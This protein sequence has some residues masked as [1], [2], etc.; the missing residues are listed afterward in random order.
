M[1]LV[2]TNK[3]CYGSSYYKYLQNNKIKSLKIDLRDLVKIKV[4]DVFNITP[5]ERKWVI[6]NKQ[7]IDLTEIKG[8]YHCFEHLDISL[9]DDFDQRDV[10]Y[11]REEWFAYIVFFLNQIKKNINPISHKRYGGSYFS[12]LSVYKFA[13]NLGFNIPMF[14]FGSYIDLTVKNLSEYVAYSDIFNFLNPIKISENEK[15]TSVV[16]LIEKPKG[17]PILVR[18]IGD[19][20]TATIVIKNQGLNEFILSDEYI[21]K[22]IM[23][24]KILEINVFEVLCLNFNNKLIFYGLSIFP[25]W[26]I[27]HLPMNYYWEQITK[28]IGE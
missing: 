7:T 20:I 14:M 28:F 26:K 16:L 12:M 3:D 2:I 10:E 11:V 19:N 4:N 6:G 9:F 13:F 21:H 15:N 8:V 18:V 22:F 1:I 5:L 25:D 23:L 24:K 17:L 27:S